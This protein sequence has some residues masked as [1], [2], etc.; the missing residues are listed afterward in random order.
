MQTE[1]RRPTYLQ[2]FRE[3]M[4]LAVVPLLGWMLL[5]TVE[6]QKEIVALRYQ[7][8]AIAKDVALH[9]TDSK[10][11]TK[12]CAALHHNNNRLR[13]NGCHSDK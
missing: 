13:C 8:A 4:T 2:W 12:E 10:D 9:N 11:D 7:V 1:R 3:I 5:Q 6:V